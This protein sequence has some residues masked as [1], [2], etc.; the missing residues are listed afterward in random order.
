MM[1]QIEFINKM[2]DVPWI[3]GKADFSEC[4]CW[5]LVELYHDRV[6]G[7]ELEDTHDMPMEEGMNAQLATGDWIEL[8]NPDSSSIVFMA[9]VN[10]RPAHCGIVIGERVLH[11]AGDRRH[12]GYCRFERLSV[13][14]NRY[15]DMRYFIHRSVAE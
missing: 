10:N 8:F 4:D 12:G 15:K 7:I 1:N 11:S 13:M 3:E 6:L 5:G 14:Q 9:Y 2:I